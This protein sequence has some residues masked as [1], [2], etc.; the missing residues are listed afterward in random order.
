MFVIDFVKSLECLSEW[1]KIIF[2]VC[3]GGE[4]WPGRNREGGAVASNHPANFFLSS[5]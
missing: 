4:G 3:V 1:M 5:P 2:C